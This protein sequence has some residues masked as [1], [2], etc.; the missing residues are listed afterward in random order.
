MRTGTFLILFM[1]CTACASSESPMSP[2]ISVPTAS[3]SI[4][5]SV[6]WSGD[7]GAECMAGVLRARM[8]ERQP[9]ASR[10]Q[11]FDVV[12]PILEIMFQGKPARL[13]VV[14]ATELEKGRVIQP[15]I[16]SPLGRIIARHYMYYFQ[17][18]EVSPLITLGETGAVTEAVIEEWDRSCNAGEM[19]LMGGIP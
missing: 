11:D 7:E 18:L 17:Y 16:D 10:F 14:S 8:P 19:W 15:P 1:A 5:P 4:E 9:R 2:Q 3:P 12:Y 13:I 6:F